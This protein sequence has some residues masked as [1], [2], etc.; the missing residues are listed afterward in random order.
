MELIAKLDINEQDFVRATQASFKLGIEFEDWHKKGE[1]YF[2]PFGSIGQQVELS[3]F[4][5]C[6]LKAKRAGQPFE[7]MDFAPAAEMAH[8]DKFMLPFKAQKTPVGALPMRCMSMR[9]ALPNSSAAMPGSAA[10]SGPRA[11]SPMSGSTIAASSTHSSSR[12]AVSHCRLLHRLLGFP[13]AADRE[14]ARRRL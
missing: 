4:Y 12:T 14:G 2:H 8:A 10:S 6:W 11:S 3:E 1:S 5:Q 13:G 9:S 7:L